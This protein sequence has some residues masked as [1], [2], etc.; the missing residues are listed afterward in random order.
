MSVQ[1]NKQFVKSL[2]IMALPS[3]QIYSGTEGLLENFPCGHSKVPMLKRKL[4]D[5]I[6][7]KIDPETLLLKD[8]DC[9]NPENAESAPCKT[10][11]LTVIDDGEAQS[12]E[13]DEVISDDRKE[14]NLLYLRTGVPYF[15]DFD[16]DQFY[17]LMDKVRF[18]RTGNS[19]PSVIILMRS[20]SFSLGQPC[21]I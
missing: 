13:I 20:Y 6:N 19:S 1:H 9:T 10:R 4:T 5:T 8:L 12:S 3:I 15:K 17:D 14:E 7:A 21:H 11:K 18:A 16:D 2:G